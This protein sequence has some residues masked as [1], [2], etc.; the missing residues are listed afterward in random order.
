MP[1]GGGA[2]TLAVAL[3]IKLGIAAK[4]SNAVCLLA[5]RGKIL[6]MREIQTGSLEA[7]EEAVLPPREG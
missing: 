6:E 1:F 3:A 2:L 5:S 7:N 4:F